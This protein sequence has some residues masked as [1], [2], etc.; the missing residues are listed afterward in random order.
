MIAHRI[1]KAAASIGVVTAVTLG[2]ALGTAGAAHADTR[3]S[4]YSSQRE[5]QSVANWYNANV[6]GY[7]YC[8]RDVQGV[9]WLW[10]GK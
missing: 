1:K 2:V 4:S 5:C 10:A 7:F 6:S 8:N 3:M 9:W